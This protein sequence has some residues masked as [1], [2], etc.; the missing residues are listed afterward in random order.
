MSTTN[1]KQVVEAL[2]TKVPEFKVDDECN[3]TI[4]AVWDF[5]WWAFNKT[6]K[7]N[8]KVIVDR[9]KFSGEF[10]PIFFYL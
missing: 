2:E 5:F 6:R 3:Q 7:I 9:K 1:L 10:Q 8:T 4:M